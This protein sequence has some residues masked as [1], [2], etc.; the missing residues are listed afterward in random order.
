MTDRQTLEEWG[1]EQVRVSAA[2]LAKCISATDLT[3]NRTCFGQVIRP[4]PGSVL[5]S[6]AVA[7]EAGE[8]DYFFHWV[9]DSAT[10]MDAVRVLAKAGEQSADWRNLFN[11]YVQ[12]SLDLRKIDGP[13]FLGTSDFRQKTLPEW[14]QYLRTNEEIAAVHGAQIAGDVR[15]NADGSL[16]FILWNRP[17][18]D[19]PA[20]RALVSMRFEEDAL[21]ISEKAKGHLAE[22]IHSDLS[23]VVKTAGQ[24][25]YDIW[26]EEFARHYYTLLVQLAA[27]ERGAARAKRNGKAADAGFFENKAKDLRKALDGFWSQNLGA[28]QSRINGPGAESPKALD[29]AVILGVLHAGFDKG[30]HSVQDER[31]L[32][33]FKKL[34][35]LFTAEYAINSGGGHGIMFGR[36]KGDTYVSGGAYY[37]S[38]FGAAE[39]YY[40]AAAATPSHREALIE[41]GDAVLARTRD[42]IPESGHLSEQFDKTSGAQSSAK[43]LSWSYACFVTAWAERRRALGLGG[44]G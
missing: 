7:F 23:Y 35:E 39:F 5:A 9:R 24:S 37:F 28:Y 44:L 27:L 34:N 10:V 40:R 6:P 21:R 31:V 15:Y 13:G 1:R 33:T 16:D 18:F 42:F 17:Q 11:E 26:E 43:D 14:Q 38:T 20:A 19:G 41:R 29:F 22:L 36:Y 8:P 25:C 32:L 12:F 2:K 30:T 4:A 3:M